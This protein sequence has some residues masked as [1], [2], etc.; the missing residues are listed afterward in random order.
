MA[1]LLE[2]IQCAGSNTRPP[3]L[4]RTDFAS[5]KQQIR[6]Y[7]RGKENG[8]NIFKSIDEGPY[9][10]GTFRETLAESTEGTPQFGPERPRVYSDLTSEEKDRFAKLINDMRNIKMTMSKLQLNSKF[11]NNMLPEW[12]RYVTAVKLNK[13][14]RDSNYDQLYAYLKHH[15]THEKENNMILER[16][17]QPTVDPLAL[18][19]N[20]SNPQHYSPSSSASS[21]A[22]DLI[23]NLTNTLALLTQS[24]R[25]F[26]PQTNNQLRTSSN[27]R[28]QATVQ[29]D[30]VVVH[31]V[32]GHLNRGQGMNPRGGNDVGYGG[33]PNRVGND[34][35]GQARPGQ[36]RTVKCY[37]CNG[38]RKRSS[39]GRRAVAVSC[40]LMT[41]MPLILMWIRLPLHKPRS[42]PI[43]SSTDPVTD[44]VGPSYDSDI[45]SE[46]PNYEHYLDAACA[47]H[48]GHV[49]HDNIQ[50]DH[51]VDS[52]AD[53]TSDSHMIPYDQYVRDNEVPVV[54]SGASSVPTDAFMMIYND[55]CE[56][57]DPS[58]SNTTRNTVV[59][60]S[61]TAKLATYKEHFELSK[62]NERCV[63][64]LEAEVAQYA[65]D[66]KRDA[67]KLKNLLI[68]ND[69]LIAECLSQE[70]FCVATNS[71][72]NVTRFTKMYVA[73][74][75]AKAR[76]SALE[77]E[78]AN[79]RDTNNHDNQK[80]LI[81]HFSKLEAQN[82]LFRVENDKIKQQYKELY[83]SIKI[84]RAKHIEKELLEYA[85]GTCPQSSQQRAKQLAYIPLIRKK[86]VTIAKPSDKSDSTTHRHVVTVKSQKTNVPVPPSI[87]VNS[88]PHASGLQPKS[89]VKS[90]RILPAKG[91]NKLPVEDQPK[92]NKSYL[93]TSNRVNSSIRLKRTVVQIV[94]WYLDSGCSKH[95]TEDRSR[96]M[97]FVKKFIRT[98][99]FRNNHF[100][101]IM[102][103]GGY[104][105]GNNVISRVYYVEGLGHN[106]FSV[107]QFCN[108]DLEVAFQ[109][110]SCY[111]RD[112]D[113]VEL[114]KGSRGS[115]LYTISI[116]DIMKS[117]PICL[118]SKASKNKSWLWHRR[119]NHLNFDI[120]NDL[121][122]KDLVRG[123]PRLKFEKD[124]L[125]S[126]CQLGKSKK[127]THKPKSK[128]TN[129][130][131]LNTLH[132]D[133][134][135]PIRVQTINE[136]KYILVIVDDYS[137]EDLGK[138]QPTADTGI[139][140]GYAPSRK[141]TSSSQ[142]SA[143]KPLSNTIDQDAPTLI[144]LPSSSAL[145]SH[146]LH[147]DVAAEPNYMEE[148]T[149][150]PVDNPPF[151]NVFAP[152]PHSEAT[153]SGDISSPDSPYV[154]QTLHR[155]NK[156]HW[157]SLSTV[158]ELVHQPDC[159]MI[160]ALKWIYKV[161]LDKYGDVLKNKT[162]LVANGYR[163]EEGI[164][165]EESF[166][167]VARIEAIRIFIANA[168]SRN[169][170]MYQM[171]VK[172]AFLNGKLKE[173]VYVSQ[174][175]G[176]VDPDHPT[177]VYRLKKALYG[178]K[179]AP[180]A[181]YDTFSRFLLDNNFSKGTVDPTLFTYKTGK[182][183]LL[184]QIYVDDIIF[185][186]TDPT[187][188]D[189]FS[190][191]MSLK[192][193]M[194]MIGQMSF[195]LGLQVSQS[196]G[197]IFIN[198]SKFALEILK[199]FR[200]DSCDSVETPMVD[201]LK[202]DE[203]PSGI[204]VD[205][206]RFRSMV[207]SLMYL[208]ASRPD[209]V[210]SVCMCAR[211]SR[212]AKKHIRKCSVPAISTTE[213][214]YIAMS[215]CCAQILWM[216]SQLTNYGFDFNKIPMYCDNRSSIAL[217]CNN[218]QH[219]RY[220]KFSAKDTKREV[221]GM[222]IPGSLITADIR[223]ASY[224]QEYLAN[225]TKHRRFLAGETRSAQDSPAPKPA[226]PARKPK[227]TAQKDRINIL[228]YLIHLRMCNDFAT[229]M[230]KM[231]LL[232]EN[233]R[234]QNPNYHE[235]YIRD[236]FYSKFTRLWVGK[237]RNLNAGSVTS[238]GTVISFTDSFSASSSDKT[239]NLIL[240]MKT[241]RIFCNLESFVGG[242]VREGDYRLL[243][244]GAN[245]VMATCGN[246]KDRPCNCF[247]RVI[248]MSIGKIKKE[249]S[250]NKG[251]VPSEMELDLEHTQ[252]GFSYEVS[253]AVCSSLQSHKSKRTIE[254]RA[255]RSSKIISLGNY[256][257]LLASLHAVKMK[258]E[259]LLEPTSNNL[260]VGCTPLRKKFKEDLFTYCIEN[261]IFQDFQDTSESSYDNTNV[262]NALQEPFVVKQDPGENFSQSTP[263]INHHCCYGCGDSLE[264]IFCHQCT[265]ESCRTGAHYGY[266]C[267]SKILIIPNPEPCNNQTIDELPQTLS[268]FD[269]TCYS[270][271]GNSFTYDFKSN[272]VHDSPNIFNPPLQP[273]LYS[274]KFCGNDAYYG[275]DCPLQVPLTYDP[276]PCYN[277]DFNFLQNF[278]IFQ[279]QYLYC[280]RCG[281]PHETCQRDQLIFDEPY[282][283]NL[284][285][286]T[287]SWGRPTICYNDDDDE[288]CTI[289]I[290]PILSTE[291]PDNSL[292]MRDEH[293]DTIP[294]TESD[295]FIK[296][297]IENLVPTL[298]ESEGIPDN[299]C[300][301][302][303]HD[304]SLPLNVSKD[305]FED[306]S[307][308]NDDSTSIDDDSF[309]IDDI[310]YVE[311][312]HPDYEL[313]SLDVME[314]VIPEEGGIDAD[315]LLTIKNDILQISSGSTTAHSDSSL[316]G[317]FIFDLSINPFPPAGR[318]DFYEFV[319]EIAQIISPQEYDCFCF[320]NEPNSGDFT[321]DLVEDIFQTREPTVHV[322]NVLPTHPTLQLNMDFILSSESLFTY[323]V[324]IF[325]PF[326]SYSVAPQYFLSFGNE[327][328]IFYPGISCYHIS[329][330]MPDVS[331]RSGTFIKFNVYLKHLNG[332][333][334]E[335]LFSICSP[336]DQ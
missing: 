128:N 34:N 24:Y 191:E 84:T 38:T 126:A 72:L 170:T 261:G 81:N 151:I 223:E 32:Q 305:Q 125:C 295:E 194:S 273:P 39:F 215:G 1:N 313:V 302:P 134:C 335:I 198:Q 200:M 161:K 35:Q 236:V 193:Q 160:I 234:Q 174:P 2:D 133:L 214:E 237:F 17:S 115:N 97:N 154:S 70:V 46:V 230:M 282:Y 61:L 304:N 86:Q 322:H 20:V 248:R 118:L 42:W 315:I 249:K 143:G 78:L 228:Q 52:H 293:L 113:G 296:S 287:L 156:C 108:S 116:E 297:S 203:D 219:S 26:L 320:K 240:R 321:M 181:W 333:L 180:Q 117:S 196:P 6:L 135:G 85:I 334:M 277:Q 27:A 254:S 190:N 331:H 329:S 129:L 316:Y 166:A 79:L 110:H 209:L 148:R 57:H 124:H 245:G 239:W 195:F 25:T 306:F 232:V 290:T 280:T 309:S 104:V 69:N 21:P 179:Q 55:M 324:W 28:N 137:S 231:F 264:E 303:F 226:K 30:R 75:T 4:D 56:S 243:K 165:F 319:D 252:Q 139:F 142:L 250:E 60:N 144:I 294:A 105:I 109:K 74:T 9:K 224:Y 171:D 169:M 102:G 216:R 29:D 83:D 256:S 92:T 155:L 173:E 14:L 238:F 36:A 251:R 278:Q 131:V 114:L 62:R 164:D 332:S 89:H 182:H 99:R 162:R 152:E 87:G 210:F 22:E 241:R 255:K 157:Q 275:Y 208:T 58:I 101:A 68:A 299:M 172:T 205:Q 76:C 221:F 259:I 19:S 80:E 192:F 272:L 289:A 276:E 188:C 201:R 311:A 175:K 207:G 53:Y 189:M 167:L 159:V 298:S 178:L 288:D 265:C 291:E 206:T 326:L 43:C 246:S 247:I 163:Q 123:L 59:K 23:E 33:A 328:T 229:K 168:T 197:G 90:N 323:V 140:V 314:I 51:F 274:Y 147:Q 8:V 66:R 300:D 13:G 111:V 186:S 73:N 44:E 330:F 11:V 119:L 327:D 12:G 222:P 130:D 96:L 7:C 211:L 63:E 262:A 267:P 177:H 336:M 253:V 82:D 213:A 325:L 212:H 217:C 270:K 98:I 187:D 40:R 71:E 285:I 158:W 242:R 292:S 318:S 94:L 312:L 15:E 146:S 301:V 227:P 281:G 64:E 45:L 153:S 127:H 317:L 225:M 258:M 260:L 37:N 271:D 136:K 279:Q 310:E 77:A 233:L 244:R 204:P 47:H 307:D 88:C 50:L 103:Y 257:I 10:M 132:M 95:M 67:I 106:L 100:S 31:N 284:Y 121:A 199:K 49:T 138:L 41:V 185:A 93:R 218:V 54:H 112:T 308:S 141:G 263:Q 16:F 183:I 145:Q 202:L 18:L 269:P 184:V 283:E 235:V 5:W 149:N 3:M 266:N 48:E 107:G 268:S 286:N 220:L 150:A 120:I 65:V 176:F 91:V 122:R